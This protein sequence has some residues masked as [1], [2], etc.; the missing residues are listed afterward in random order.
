M[1]GVFARATVKPQHTQDFEKL[2]R[3]LHQKSLAEDGVV[4][5]DFGPMTGEGSENE[6]AFIER[7]ESIEHLEAHM[8]TKHYK[9]ADTDCQEYLAKPMQISIY[10]I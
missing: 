5:Y 3:T 9:K 2:S 8:E 10:E 1:I 7:W 6:F 4:S